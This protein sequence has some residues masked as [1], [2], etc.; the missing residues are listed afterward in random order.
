MVH[1]PT[2]KYF[3]LKDKIQALVD[4]GVLTMKLEQKKVITY[5][6]THNFGTF[7]K[8]TVQDGVAPAPEARME[9]INPF[10]KE[11]EAKGLV[12][13]TIKSEKIMW[14]HP[15]IVKD[16]KHELSQP[17]L[18][19]KSCNIISLAVD[20]N[21]LTVTSLSSSKKRSLPSQRSPLPCSR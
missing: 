1:H 3:V 19:G 8:V 12:P 10:A 18:K 5:M 7:L 21:T 4:V 13:L 17:K 15:D 20:D 2:S 11:Q 9:V 6:V 16:E 14:V